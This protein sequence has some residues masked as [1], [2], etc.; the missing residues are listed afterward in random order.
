VGYF[1]LLPE[2]VRELACRAS[3]AAPSFLKALPN[4]LVGVT[5]RGEVEKTLLF[6]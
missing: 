3:L 2:F 6:H 1:R 5:Q 4:A